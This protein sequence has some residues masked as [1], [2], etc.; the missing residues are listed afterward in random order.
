MEKATSHFIVQC[1]K[2][3]CRFRYP[4]AA[5]PAAPVCPKCGGPVQVIHFPAQEAASGS[6]LPP[7]G[8]MEVLLD[9]L[10]SAYNVGSIL[11]TADAVQ[12]SHLYLAGTTPTPDHP[13]VRKTS[14]GAEFSAP[15]TLD[16]NAP[17]IILGLR[18]EGRFIVSL[19]LAPNAVSLFDLK[20]EQLRFPLLLVVGS[21]VN[22]V[23]PEVLGLSDL[24]IQ[25]P[26]LGAKG[27]VNVASAFAVAVYLLR[28]LDIKQASPE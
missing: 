5:L 15:W 9:N 13:R 25:I 4:A 3:V 20:T 22:G 26:M 7:V 21:E 1:L 27:S 18:K 2:P 24:V 16:W 19:E 8:R 11:R 6:S 28:Y 17:D 10:R 14:L 12:I 23:D